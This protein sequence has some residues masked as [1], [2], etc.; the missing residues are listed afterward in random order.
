[1]GGMRFL[2]S[3]M[4]GILDYIVGAALLLAP[5]IFGFSDVGGAAVMIPRIIGV[6]ILVQGILTRYELGVIKVL[7]FSLHVGI[8]YVVGIFLAG[9]PI[10]FGFSDQPTNVW[11]PHVLFGAFI[12]F[13]TLFTE[14][15]PGYSESDPTIS[16][17]AAR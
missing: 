6:L 4:H 17:T 7:P 15:Q 11:L 5:E 8:D 1:M 9:S 13:S 16:N 2:S 12:F 3:R 14:T 10:L